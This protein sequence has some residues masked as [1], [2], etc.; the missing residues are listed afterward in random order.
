MR[1][2][3]PDCQHY[4][5]TICPRP[6]GILLSS[7]SDQSACSPWISRVHSTVSD[8]RSHF[9]RAA[10]TPPASYERHR[11]EET[12]LY[13]IVAIYYPKFLARLEAEGA[14][15]P[16]LVQQEFDDYLKCGLLEHGFR[17]VKYDARSHEHLVAFSCKRRGFCPSCGARRL[18][19]SAAHRVDHVLPE[20]PI[21][22]WAPTLRHL[23]I[24]W[25]ATVFAPPGFNNGP[26]F[27]DRFKRPAIQVYVGLLMARRKHGLVS[28]IGV[29]SA[30][31][32]PNK[33]IFDIGTN[34]FLG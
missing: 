25:T 21:R 1:A 18:V 20:Q 15:L 12:P 6:G 11:P 9:E 26:G 34:W 30:Q 23:H 13:G 24:R 29:Y 4:S 28:R 31:T 5:D 7:I 16:Q 27:T 10:L 32:F 2:I 8:S 22:Q 19:E 3:I 33:I 17:R 14:S